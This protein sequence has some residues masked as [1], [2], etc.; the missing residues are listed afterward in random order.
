MLEKELLRH[1]DVCLVVRCLHRLIALALLRMECHDS[2]FAAWPCILIA[3]L[4]KG[5]V[6][7]QAQTFAK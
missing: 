6:S 3:A 1:V 5:S 2:D 4:R 7:L